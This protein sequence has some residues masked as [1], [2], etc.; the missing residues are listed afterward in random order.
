MT[1]TFVFVTETGGTYEKREKMAVRGFGSCH[2][3]VLTKG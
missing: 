1:R 2:G 3:M